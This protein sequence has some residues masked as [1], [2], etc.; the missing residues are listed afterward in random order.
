MV[1]PA[2]IGRLVGYARVSTDDQDLSRQIE[3]LTGLS[4][5]RYDEPVRRIDLSHLL[6]PRSVRASIDSGANQGWP[7]IRAGKGQARRP[8]AD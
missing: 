4:I 2:L 1:A 7:S 6:G 5:N 8:L 3:L